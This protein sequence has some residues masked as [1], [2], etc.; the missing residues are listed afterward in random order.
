VYLNTSGRVVDPDMGTFDPKTDT[1][2]GNDLVKAGG[3][4]HHEWDDAGAVVNS[5]AL[6]AAMVNEAK[7]VPITAGPLS[8]WSTLWA[9]ESLLESKKAFT[10]ITYSSEDSTTHRYTITL[11]ANYATKRTDI[12]RKQVIKAG[13]RLA[14]VLKTIWP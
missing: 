3:N 5:N 9:T 1:T 7:A 10:G 12:Q 14:Q 11:P 2:G 8:G 4:L 6:S 13:A